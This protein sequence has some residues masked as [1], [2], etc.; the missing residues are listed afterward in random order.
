MKT[1]VITYFLVL[2]AVMLSIIWF[3]EFS[4]LQLTIAF[5]I[6]G[7]LIALPSIRL[8][9]AGKSEGSSE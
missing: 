5:L 7:V 2:M 8:N 9:R 3:A 4:K 1:A 6:Y